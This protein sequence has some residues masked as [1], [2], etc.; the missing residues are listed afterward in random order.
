MSTVV[1][2]DQ[3]RRIRPKKEVRHM[4]IDARDQREGQTMRAVGFRRYGPPDVLETLEVAR[5]EPGPGRSS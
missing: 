5:P 2:Y 1:R 4:T 3:P